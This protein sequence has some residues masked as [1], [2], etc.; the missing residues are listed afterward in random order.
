MFF[1]IVITDLMKNIYSLELPEILV[2]FWQPVLYLLNN[3]QLTPRLLDHL[4]SKLGETSSLQDRIIA[5]WISMI[6]SAVINCG[7]TFYV[8]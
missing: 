6:L 5:G 8:I 4:A 3:L 2:L 7:N 1:K